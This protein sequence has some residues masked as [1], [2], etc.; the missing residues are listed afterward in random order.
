MASM[1]PLV[2]FDAAASAVV[3]AQTL[4]R[5]F[6]GSGALFRF[7]CAIS[8]AAVDL[9]TTVSKS[10]HSAISAH[11]LRLAIRYFGKLRCCSMSR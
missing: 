5:A 1:K 8:D 10:L 7:L 3:T 2:C 6:P 9:G 11:A 4:K